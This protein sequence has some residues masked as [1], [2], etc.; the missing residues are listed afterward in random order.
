MNSSLSTVTSTFVGVLAG[1]LV[2][3]AMARYYYRQAAKDLEKEAERFAQIIDRTF[4]NFEQSGWVSVSRGPDG[5][6]VGLTPRLGL[7]ARP[8]LP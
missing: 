2:T 1:G 5:K 3:W 6:V 8:P 4:T 7:G